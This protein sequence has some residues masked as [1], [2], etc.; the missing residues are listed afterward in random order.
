MEKYVSSERYRK[1]ASAFSIVD[2]PNAHTQCITVRISVR[3]RCVHNA[4]RAGWLAIAFGRDICFRHRI[5]ERT[6]RP[7]QLAQ[8]TNCVCARRGQPNRRRELQAKRRSYGGDFVVQFRGRL[9]PFF[10]EKETSC[11]EEH[12]C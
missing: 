12:P 8:S 11:N 10:D 1:P 3:A 9:A 6:L 7:A 5:R 2:I 4:K